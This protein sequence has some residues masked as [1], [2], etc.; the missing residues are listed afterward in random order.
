MG[1]HHTTIEFVPTD[2]RDA[3][4][5]GTIKSSVHRYRVKLAQPKAITQ[6]L[7]LETGGDG[8]RLSGR[9]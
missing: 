8:G 2:G 7:A 4:L 1:A 3:E 5:L 6:D 9:S